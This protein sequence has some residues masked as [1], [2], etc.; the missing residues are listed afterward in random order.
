[1]SASSLLEAN[2]YDHDKDYGADKLKV[3]A[4]QFSVDERNLQK[5]WNVVR[6]TVSSIRDKRPHSEC[7][8]FPT[9]STL[10]KTHEQ[11]EQ[12][13]ILKK[14]MSTYLVLPM[15]SVDAERGFSVLKLVKVRLRN[16]LGALNLNHAMMTAIEGPNIEN[17]DFAKCIKLFKASKRRRV[18]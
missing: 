9:I 15:S 8:L 11:D 4:T 7:Q 2:S 13:P 17:F 16:S 14:M 6:H 10:L 3:L 5:E 12:I 1:M 18:V